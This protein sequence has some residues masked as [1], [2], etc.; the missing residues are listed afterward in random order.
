MKRVV[1]VGGGIAGLSAAYYI[2]KSG[3]AKVTLLEGSDRLGGKIGTERV[4]DF[5]VEEGPDSIFTVKPAAVELAVE[6]GMEEDL[7]EPRQSEFSI[8]VGGELFSV[9]RS[10]A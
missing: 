6:L 3:D 8:L 1:I 10:L 7:I 4:G 2:Q 5:L 9:P